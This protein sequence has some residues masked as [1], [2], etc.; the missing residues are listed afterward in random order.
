MTL[1]PKARASTVVQ[2]AW[3]Q[4]RTNRFVCR[5]RGTWLRPR[6]DLYTAF[7]VCRCAVG[8]LRRRSRAGHGL[9]HDPGITDLECVGARAPRSGFQVRARSPHPLATRACALLRLR[10]CSLRSLLP[11][12][13][14][15][16]LAL[17]DAEGSSKPASSS[18]WRHRLRRRQRACACVL[19][20]HALRRKRRQR[21]AACAP[22]T[23]QRLS[24]PNSRGQTIAPLAWARTLPPEAYADPGSPDRPDRPMQ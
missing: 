9:S 15:S 2:R 4:P 22:P 20:P 3:L 17:L 7:A 6:L 16:L 11:P 23:V 19:P 21:G 18:A 1:H 13:P 8:H 5:L 10:C 14:R 24:V 12:P